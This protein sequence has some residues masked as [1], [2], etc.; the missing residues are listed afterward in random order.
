MTAGANTV[1]Q[2]AE[3]AATTASPSAQLRNFALVTVAQLAEFD[4]IIDTRSESEF[5]EDHI[6]GAINC[7]VLNDAERVRVGTLYKQVS[8]FAAKRIGA[9][10]VSRN[11]AQHLETRLADHPRHWRPLV[12]CWRGGTRSEAF[13]HVLHQVG[14]RVGRLDGGYKAYRRALL[15]D[16]EELPRELRWRV[17]CGPTGS[18]KSRFLQALRER[19]AQVL[20][21]EAL[22]AHRGSVLGDLPGQPQPAQKMFESLL[23]AEL[24]RFSSAAPVFVEAE[25]KQ[26]G[27]LNL[28]ET[29]VG[30]MRDSECLCLDADIGTRVEL[31]KG[32][33]RH[34]VL[35]PAAL[36]TQLAT[37][38]SRHGTRQIEAWDAL[39]AQQRW[40]E[41]VRELLER[42]YDPAYTRSTEKNYPAYHAAQRLAV[43]GVSDAA[44]REIAGRCLGGGG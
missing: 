6:P 2:Q 16:F 31:L 41:L 26:I 25:S 29:L 1:L 33:Y 10:L 42:H 7:P 13:A 24:R 30:A 23:W 12:Y 43:T 35:D 5:A 20:D 22:A 21:L 38:V 11:I 37:L 28:P 9:A 3:T 32:E 17:V 4:E 34:F 15:R 40:D 27:T 18:G 36:A 14:W 39:A 44:F 19:G 8:P